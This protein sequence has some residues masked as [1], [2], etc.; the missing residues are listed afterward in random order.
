MILKSQFRHFSHDF[1]E[2]IDEFHKPVENYAELLMH[3]T[4]KTKITR[5]KP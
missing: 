4:K 3:H 5:I 2:K 1:C